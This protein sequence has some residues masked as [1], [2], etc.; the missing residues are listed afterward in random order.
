MHSS[1]LPV[2]LFLLGA[3]ALLG[4]MQAVDPGRSWE[5]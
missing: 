3:M 5:G 1:C 4:W 2:I